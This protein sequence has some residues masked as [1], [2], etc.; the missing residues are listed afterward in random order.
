MSSPKVTGTRSLIVYCDCGCEHKL[1]VSSKTG[2]YELGT[3][4][5]KPVTAGEGLPPAAT[6]PQRKATIF[7]A[8][9]PGDDDDDEGDEE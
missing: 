2:E 5:K 1:T 6:K 9:I 8:P 4:A 7:D 3:T